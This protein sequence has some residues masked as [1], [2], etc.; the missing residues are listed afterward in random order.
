M[1]SVDSKNWTRPRADTASLQP[2]MRKQTSRG[3]ETIQTGI[4]GLLIA[5]RRWLHQQPERLAISLGI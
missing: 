4:A 2:K 5:S 3:S 1:G